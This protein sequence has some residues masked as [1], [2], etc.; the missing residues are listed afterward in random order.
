[1]ILFEIYINVSCEANATNCGLP[2]AG[3]DFMK[4]NHM[5]IKEHLDLRDGE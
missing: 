1:M 5:L 2:F 4:F 3:L